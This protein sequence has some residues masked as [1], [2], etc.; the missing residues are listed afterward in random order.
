ML[1]VMTEAFAGFRAAE[2]RGIPLFYRRDRR[3]KTFRL[4]LTTRR[5][6]DERAAARSLLSPLMLEGVTTDPERPTLHRRMESLYGATVAPGTG[7][8]GESHLLTFALDCVAGDY[9]PGKP[10]QLGA[11]LAF[12]AEILAHPRLS[13]DGFPDDVFQREQR[14]AVDD[15]RA[16]FDDKAE[17]DTH[18]G[19]TIFPVGKTVSVERGMRVDVHFVL[20][21]QGKG[22]SRATWA[23]EVEGYRF[24]S[25]DI[26]VL[27]DQNLACEQNA[28]PDRYPAVRHTGR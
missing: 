21:P 24:Q 3:F 12:L 4:T 11:G 25:E 18:W 28:A 9:L 2:V 6:L 7:K 13:G 20:E 8:L 1:P 26:T 10:D 14:Q 27:T 23:I 5:P 16:L 17:R 22:Q 15:V 19:R